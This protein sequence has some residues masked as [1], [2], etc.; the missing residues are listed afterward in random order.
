MPQISVNPESSLVNL[1]TAGPIPTVDLIDQGHGPSYFLS[2]TSHGTVTAGNAKVS[3]H[4]TTDTGSFAQ[5]QADLASLTYAGT[6]NDV[7]SIQVTDTRFFIDSRANFDRV[8]NVAQIAVD[9]FPNN[10]APTLSGPISIQA[11]AGQGTAVSGLTLADQDGGPG[12]SLAL[13]ASAGSLSVQ[14]LAGIVTGSGASL[15]I[16]GGLSD[17]NADL[18]TL[19]FNGQAGTATIALAASDGLDSSSASVML[20]I[21]EPPPPPPP[22]VAGSGGTPPVTIGGGTAPTVP[23]STAIDPT[24]NLSLNLSDSAT[25]QTLFGLTGTDMLSIGGAGAAITAISGSDTII[26]SGGSN[27]FSAI[28]GN[29][30]I[31]AEAGTNVLAGGAG[32][33]AFTLDGGSSTVFTGTGSNAIAITGGAAT[34]VALQGTSTIQGTGGA[35]LIGVLGGSH[36]ITLTVPAVVL[37]T[38]GSATISGASGAQI[39]LLGGRDQITVDAATIFSIASTSTVTG[40]SGVLAMDLVG[41]TTSITAGTGLT[42]LFVNDGTNTLAVQSGSTILV[43]GFTPAHLALSIP[44]DLN[45]ANFTTA[46]DIPTLQGAAGTLLDLGHTTTG[47]QLLLLIGVTQFDPSSITLT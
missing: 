7:L 10:H 34:I 32:A 45:G 1:R 29:H 12:F 37:A 30:S 33:N 6:A 38:G 39:G 21:A 31:T 40:G 23:S 44:H 19:T 24:A 26:I 3:G 5:I 4:T 11:T 18:A 17:I 16:T 27:S 42:E 22:T 28:G 15:T 14:Q 20:S 41:G 2:I 9:L 36:Q 46:S 13:S 25:A 35:E 43:A 8:S 47:E